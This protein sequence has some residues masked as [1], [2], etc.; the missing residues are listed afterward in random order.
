MDEM[1]GLKASWW[2]RPGVWGVLACVSLASG[3][4]GATWP[5]RSLDLR[6][7]LRWAATWDFGAVN[8]Y[9]TGVLR[10]DYPPHAFL[11]L[12]P[13][14]LLPADLA[15]AMFAVVNTIICV[16]AAWVTVQV[17]MEVPGPT[18]TRQRQVLV[19]VILTFGVF[20]S[21]L[22]LGQ[23]MPLAW[24]LLMLAVREAARRPALAGVCL[25]LGAF[26]LNLALGVVLCLLA[27]GRR[28]VLL[29]AAVTMAIGISVVAWITGVEPW[30]MT[31]QYVRGMVRM[32][33]PG[34]YVADWLSLRALADGPAARAAI[35]AYLAITGA[36][37]A[38]VTVR[39]NVTGAHALALWC[40]WSLQAVSHQRF[41]FVLAVPAVLL[42][43]QAVRAGVP[44][45]VFLTVAGFLAVDAPWI[46]MHAR[47]TAPA[48]WAP[49]LL[50]VS[51][52]AWLGWRARPG[53]GLH[54][55]LSAS[56]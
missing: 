24:L 29:W 54:P 3:V 2:E 53:R 40:L 49:R 7:V 23:L 28:T 16:L 33:G 46:L 27:Q 45:W 5:G 9:T 44:A 32:Y 19:L 12:G 48:D 31:E 43:G 1:S 8:P 20:R 52:F 6:E 25:G 39:R 11:L 15:P 37:V 55:G 56:V 10:V 38:W 21:S 51:L 4:W 22:W 36:L 30:V 14:H 18:A 17:S 34:G 47:W 42:L 26:K 13:L 41:N 50:M 35:A